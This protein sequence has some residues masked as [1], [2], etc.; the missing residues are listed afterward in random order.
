MT[1]AVS[2]IVVPVNRGTRLLL[3]KG[4]GVRMGLQCKIEYYTLILI[5]IYEAWFEFGEFL[6]EL[7]IFNKMKHKTLNY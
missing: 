3:R 6:Y 5:M 2:I 1:A 7:P 4:A